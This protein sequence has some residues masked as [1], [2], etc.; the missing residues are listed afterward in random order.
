MKRMQQHRRPGRA[1][2]TTM[3]I[4]GTSALVPPA[5]YLGGQADLFGVMAAALG[6]AGV[7]VWSQ[8]R[9]SPERVS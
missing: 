8:S 5:V 3:R 7:A 1:T 2:L 6:A 9:Q 4:L